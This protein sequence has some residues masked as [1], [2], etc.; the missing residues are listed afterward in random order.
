MV[1]KRKNTRTESDGTITAVPPRIH[2]VAIGNE[3]LNGE[4]RDSNLAWLIK[5]FTRRGGEIISATIIPDDFSA[6]EHELRRAQETAADLMVTTGGLGPTDD[7]ATMAAIG[8]CV[9]SPLELNEEALGYVKERIRELAKFRPG[10]PRRLNKERK[11]MA[12]FPV[13]GIP[14]RNPVGVAPGMM[15]TVKATTL[16]V[17]PGVPWEMKGIITDTLKTFWKTFFDSICYVRRNVTLK[18][19]PEAELARFI[20]RCQKADPGVYIK[21]RLKVTG[22]IR[23]KTSIGSVKKIPWQIVLHFSVIECTL[24]QG[25]ERVDRLI[26][27]LV[28]DLTKNYRYPLDINLR[29]GRV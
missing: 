11:S 23:P 21:S 16:I 12:V 20:R 3:L 25:H 8:Y 24:E 19:I 17:L 28:K 1:L 5:F 6:V 14:L 9:N 4:I 27:I 7:D 29:P 22:K 2:L 18:G 10:M 26:D 15:Y 13:G